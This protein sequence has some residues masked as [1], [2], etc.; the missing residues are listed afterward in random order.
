M[1][2]AHLLVLVVAQFGEQEGVR[3]ALSDEAAEQ[4]ERYLF[5]DDIRGL[6]GIG[7]QFDT[8]RWGTGLALDT[9]LTIVQNPMLYSCSQRSTRYLQYF[10]APERGK[11][12]EV[13]EAKLRGMIDEGLPTRWFCFRLTRG[14]SSDYVDGRA[15][16]WSANAT[17]T[18]KKV[19]GALG[20]GPAIGNLEAPADAVCEACLRN[21]TPAA[22]VRRRLQDPDFPRPVVVV[23]RGA[24]LES[25]VWREEVLRTVRADYRLVGERAG[26]RVGEWLDG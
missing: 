24:P 23:V 16:D 25:V 18:L 5:H 2:L 26:G 10:H 14:V 4:G 13:T 15:K 19:P 7:V 6:D 21:E 9:G 3:R 12:D 20:W 11:A 17:G 1:L 22:C 8:I